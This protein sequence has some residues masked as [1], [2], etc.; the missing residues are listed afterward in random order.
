MRLVPARLSGILGLVFSDHSFGWGV[1]AEPGNRY[2]VKSF[3]IM[4]TYKVLSS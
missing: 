4:V 1:L 2:D 3:T